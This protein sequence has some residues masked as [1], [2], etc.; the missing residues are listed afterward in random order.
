VTQPCAAAYVPLCER[1]SIDNVSQRRWAPQWGAPARD[2]QSS[3]ESVPGVFSK[4]APIAS[5]E[6]WTTLAAILT[7]GG[8]MCADTRTER[9]GSA[10]ELITSKPRGEVKMQ[11][12]PSTENTGTKPTKKAKMVQMPISMFRVRCVSPALFSKDFARS[13]TRR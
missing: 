2:I 5:L 4:E 6:R 11:S 8:A 12:E 3:P 10:E 13:A 7:R 1:A 9:S